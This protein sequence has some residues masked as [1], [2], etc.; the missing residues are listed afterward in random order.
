MNSELCKK[1]NF[2][3]KTTKLA[4][5]CSLNIFFCAGDPWILLSSKSE[6]PLNPGEPEVA[7]QKSTGL[8]NIESL[9]LARTHSPPL[10]SPP[11]FVYHPPLLSSPLLLLFLSSTFRLY[12]VYLLEDHPPVIFVLY[13]V[14]HREDE[15]LGENPHLLT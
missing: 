8:Y 15:R 12:R 10:L 11:L 5:L 6:K 4:Y 7:A 2:Y 14:I 1:V 13:V 9:A 3:T